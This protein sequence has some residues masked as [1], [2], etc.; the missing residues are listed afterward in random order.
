MFPRPTSDRTVRGSALRGAVFA[1]LGSALAAGLHHATGDSPVSLP[2]VGLAAC[3]LFLGAFAV[4]TFC[5]PRTTV[6]VLAAAQALLPLWL[7]TTEPRTVWEDHFRLPPAWHHSGPLMA[8]LNL[9]AALALAWLLRSACELPARLVNACLEPARQWLIRRAGALSPFLPALHE[10]AVSRPVR[11]AA[12]TPPPAV[13]FLA[14]RHQRVPC[15][16]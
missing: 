16:P 9:A 2:A 11:R 1:V 4:F 12:D 15:G 13:A 8:G 7:D 14:L 5:S 10:S 6:G 3:V